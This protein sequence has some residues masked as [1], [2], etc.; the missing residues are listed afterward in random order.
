M[1][2]R[3]ASNLGTI[4]FQIQEGGKRKMTYQ[5]REAI[6][7][8]EALHVSDIEKLCGMKYST[9]AK[10]IRDMKL[11]RKIQGKIVRINVD[12]YIH[13]SDYLEEIGFDPKS[14][15]DRYCK[16]EEKSAGERYL[17][18]RSPQRRSLCV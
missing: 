7:S 11:K 9:A 13:T 3:R 17:E 5:E 4:D 14:P 16:K 8:K 2:Q 6:F 1:L 18:E 15:G 10:F 12:G